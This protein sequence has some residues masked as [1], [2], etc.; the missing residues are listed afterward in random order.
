MLHKSSRI[1][2]LIIKSS[3]SYLTLVLVVKSNPCCHENYDENSM[4]ILTPSQIYSLRATHMFQGSEN[5]F[6][7]E[8]C[9]IKTYRISIASKI[10]NT[11][12]R[13]QR[14]RYV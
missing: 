5:G 1:S 13:V 2:W 8:K 10:C 3:K 14:N 7:C 9:V 6:F 11:M 12:Y 4:L